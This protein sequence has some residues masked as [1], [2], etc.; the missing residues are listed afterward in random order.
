[1]CQW[2]LVPKADD[3]YRRRW[4]SGRTSSITVFSLMA[5]PSAVSRRRS[6]SVAVSFSPQ[7]KA[8]RTFLPTAAR[9][10]RRMGGISPPVLPHVILLPNASRM[11]LPAALILG[12]LDSILS[13]LTKAQSD[14][15]GVRSSASD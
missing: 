8:T 10:A 9:A 14:A 3:C 11:M 12:M 5:W 13:M 2:P 4:I 6:S 1:V 7:T 15:D